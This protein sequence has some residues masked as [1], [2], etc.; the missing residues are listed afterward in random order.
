MTTTTVYF[1][2]HGRIHNPQ[3][4]FYG[5][6]LPMQLSQEGIAEIKELAHQLKAYKV[7]FEAM[8][9][10]PLHRAV[11]TTQT[12]ADILFVPYEHIYHMD[13]LIDAQIPS[14]AGK[15]LTLRE[16][17]HSG[18]ADEYSGKYLRLGHES[19]ANIV[20]RMTVALHRVLKNQSGK[21]VALVSHGDSL[22]FLLFRLLQKRGKIP[23]MAVLKSIYY[24]PKGGG[25][26]MVFDEKGNILEKKTI[27]EGKELR[28]QY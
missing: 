4:V 6:H 24:P 17:I 1:I 15:P 21:I 8:Y 3:K 19:R 18:G 10:S 25:W 11:T 2:R 12:L 26:Y 16:Q 13:E 22:R 28:I 9:T 27:L 14:L 20:K 23:S 7:H 5:R